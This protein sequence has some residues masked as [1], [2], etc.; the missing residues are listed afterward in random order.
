MYGYPR[1]FDYFKKEEPKIK[2]EYDEGRVEVNI[3][4][5][6]AEKDYYPQN[7]WGDP[8]GLSQ[9]AGTNQN[10]PDNKEIPSETPSAFE[11]FIRTPASAY[12][13][14]PA[15]APESATVSAPANA[16]VSTTGS[17]P[18]STTAS[19]PASV[20]SKADDSIP[21]SAPESTPARVSED[22]KAGALSVPTV[23]SLYNAPGG[24]GVPGWL[25]DWYPERKEKSSVVINIICSDYRIDRD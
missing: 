7:G 13:S 3:I 4:E 17:T 23:Q 14:A 25:R 24:Y 5:N 12:A 8:S 19:S 9:E 10:A 22:A 2:N 6:N 16:T 18:D 15:S 20:S 21:S 1:Y 11:S